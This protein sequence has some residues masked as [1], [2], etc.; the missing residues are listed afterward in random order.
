MTSA[1][2]D[3]QVHGSNSTNDKTSKQDDDNETPVRRPSTTTRRLRL[4]RQFTQSTTIHN[5]D[6]EPIEAA[7]VDAKSIACG[8]ASGVMQAGL[9]SPYDRALYLSMTNR[10]PFLSMDNFK[11]P[12]VGLSQSIGG[13]ALSGGLYFPLEQF[14]F[15]Q[16]HPATAAAGPRDNSKIRNFLAGTAAGA[17]NAMILNPLS[18]IKYKTWSRMYN[19]GMFEEAFSMLQK[20]GRGVFYR[21]LTSTLLRDIHFGGCYTFIRLQLQ[22]SWSLQNE[23]QWFANLIAAALATIV[24]GP[25]NLARN[26]QY[27]TKSSEIAPTTL[28]VLQELI[29]ETKAMQGTRQRTSFLVERLR[30]GWGTARVATG[31]AFGH[32]VYDGLHGLVHEQ[33]ESWLSNDNSRSGGNQRVRH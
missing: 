17:L 2:Q 33:E 26:V 19:R 31:I 21:G 23:H 5:V 7:S 3:S 25:F 11:S 32:W 1:G 30:L 12:F 15:Q 9:Y 10:T 6:T 14:F 16:F 20:G 8:L 24:S 29:R 28:Q 18:A 4:M 13:R 22:W 27:A